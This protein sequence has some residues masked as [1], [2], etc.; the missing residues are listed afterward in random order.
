MLC[1]KVVTQFQEVNMKTYVFDIDGTICSL[2]NDGDYRK[3]KPYKHRIEE[4][5]KLYEQ[6][7]IIIFLTAR[8]MGRY[9]N[10]KNMA[11]TKFLSLTKKQLNEW[12]VKHHDLFMGKPAGDVYIDDKGI[13]DENFFNSKD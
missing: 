3:A 5:N 2:V 8:G 11:S 4:I 7:N 1:T 10:D 6:G 13:K 12:N 9:N